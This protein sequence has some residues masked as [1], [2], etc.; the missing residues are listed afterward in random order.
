MS[1]LPENHEN[2]N[3]PK[4]KHLEYEACE[5][6]GMF[7]DAGGFTDYKYE[8][9]LDIFRDAVASLKRASKDV[10]VAACRAARLGALVEMPSWVRPDGIFCSR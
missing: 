5:E 3:D 6:H 9:L 10:R 7:M 2:L 1:A 8:T 4:Q